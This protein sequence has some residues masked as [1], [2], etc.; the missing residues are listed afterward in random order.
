[1]E[2]TL[3]FNPPD[4]APPKWHEIW[5]YWLSI[6]CSSILFTALLAGC[7]VKIR[8]WK[9]ALR[10]NNALVLLVTIGKYEPPE[11]DRKNEVYGTMNDLNAIEI[12][13]KN[14]K[15][16][17]NEKLHYDVFP[18]SSQVVWNEKDL[19][20]FLESKAEYLSDNVGKGLF[21]DSLVVMISGHG[22]PR[23]V[24]T[25]DYRCY[26]KVAIHRTFSVHANLRN[27]PRFI[28]YDCCQGINSREK[29]EEEEIKLD[30]QE[31]TNSTAEDKTK[32]IDELD[33]FDGKK[34]P[35]WKKDQSNPDHLLG[36]VNAAND[37]FVSNLNSRKGSWVIYK[38]YSKYMDA[39]KLRGRT[40]Y[41]HTVFDAIQT[42]LQ[43][44]GMQLPECTWNDGIRYLT[45]GRR[46]KQNRENVEEQLANISAVELEEVQCAP[47]PNDDE[48]KE[49]VTEI[50]L[51]ENK[52]NA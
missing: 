19:K 13:Y 30:E 18:T 35:K 51:N 40:P 23:Y 42:E 36:R 11:D 41:I 34:Q 44:D 29:E 37:G 45:F 5:Y 39:L 16:L 38:M 25:S 50:V 14:M 7:C 21:Y 31:K 24:C 47:N 27:I 17:F 1:M 6:V 15:E 9:R 20:D 33:I 8:A 10:V 46:A 3:L 48:E 52:M 26:S 22:I 32:R 49:S 4:P 12:D 2:E 43:L 28:L